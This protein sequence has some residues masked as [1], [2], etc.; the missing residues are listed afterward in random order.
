MTHF[1]LSYY[2]TQYDIPLYC[3]KQED[4]PVSFPLHKLSKTWAAA[5][6]LHSFSVTLYRGAI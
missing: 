2:E 6:L 1:S 4:A 3:Y 5:L